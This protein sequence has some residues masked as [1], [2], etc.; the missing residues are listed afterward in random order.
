MKI[1]KA[2]VNGKITA[3]EDFLKADYLPEKLEIKYK[4]QLELLNELLE[5]FNKQ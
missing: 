1:A 2:I 5:D 4:A 3:I